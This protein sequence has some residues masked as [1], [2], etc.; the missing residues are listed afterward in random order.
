MLAVMTPADYAILGIILLFASPFILI[1]LVL[2]LLWRAGNKQTVVVQSPV[3]APPAQMP[4][5]WYPDMNDPSMQ[6]YFDG[7]RWTSVVHPR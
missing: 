2:G 3:V 1:V 6:R 7:N 5:G 4:A